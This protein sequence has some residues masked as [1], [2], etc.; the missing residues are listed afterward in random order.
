MQPKLIILQ[1][2]PACGKSTRAA[3]LVQ[4]IG[5]DRAVIVCRDAIREGCGDYFVPKREAYIT[6][7]EHFMVERALA[8][9]FTVIVDA[10]NLHPQTKRAWKRMAEQFGIEIEW[11]ELLLPFDEALRRDGRADRKRAVG[12]EVLRR[13]YANYY[14]HLLPEE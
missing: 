1:G 13:F 3:Q 2:P 4:Q 12:E 11:E 9:G 5:S 8:E 14:P 10:T 6:A 7:V